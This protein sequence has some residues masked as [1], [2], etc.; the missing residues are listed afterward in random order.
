MP[1]PLVIL[2][3]PAYPLLQWVMKPYTDNGRLTQQESTFNYRLS[4]ARVVTENAFEILKGCWRF[5][6]KRN[7]TDLDQMPTL[8]TACVVL[9]SICEV[10]GDHIDTD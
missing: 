2:G 6:M 7:D 5:L 3:D 8:V 10:T 1:I 4:R 9:H